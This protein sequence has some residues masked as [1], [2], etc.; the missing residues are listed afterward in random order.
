MAFF[1]SPENV[2][3][4]NFSRFDGTRSKNEKATSHDVRT[5]SLNQK[6]SSIGG[7]YGVH[8][9]GETKINFLKLKLRW[10]VDY[11]SF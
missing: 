2:T 7:I 4:R 9:I 11:Y 10:H 3:I 1:L 5:K 8:E 6:K